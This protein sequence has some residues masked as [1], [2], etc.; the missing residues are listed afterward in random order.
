M[1]VQWKPEQLWKLLDKYKYVLLFAIPFVL[2]FRFLSLLPGLTRSQKNP[3]KTTSAA[4]RPIP[5]TPAVK[6]VPI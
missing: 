1:R 6:K 4:I 5:T 2:T 3:A